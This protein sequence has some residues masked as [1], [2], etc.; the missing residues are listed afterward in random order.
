MQAESTF[1]L[2]DWVTLTVAGTF[3]TAAVNTR[4]RESSIDK[5]S[6]HGSLITFD[7]LLLRTHRHQ[8]FLK[9]LQNEGDFTTIRLDQDALISH[10]YAKLVLV[11][12]IGSAC[13][14]ILLRHAN[15]FQPI[16]LR[17]YRSRCSVS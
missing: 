1:P 6:L 13:E 15:T 12:A 16:L 9:L 10:E 11:L 14:A 2:D 7:P 17:R 5:R 4:V 8:A 3:W